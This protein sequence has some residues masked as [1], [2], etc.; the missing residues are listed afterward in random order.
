MKPENGPTDNIYSEEITLNPSPEYMDYVLLNLR[1]I[2]EK[3]RA[4]RIPV[5][6][7]AGSEG[8]TTTKRMITTILSEKGKI[9]ETPLDCHS[10]S[11]VSSTILK[12]NDSYQFAVL[13][14]GII[15]P[16]QFKLA[17]EVAQPNIG[18][19]TNIGE[20][21]LSNLGDKYLLADAKVELIRSLPEDGFAILNVDDDLVSGME[22]FSP[23]SR[24]VK[25]GLNRNAHFSASQI[26]F[27]GPEGI[28]FVVNDYYSFKLPV[29][30]ITSVLN[31][32][33]A[34]AVAR[35]LGI[36]FEEIRDALETR[37]QLLPGRGGLIHLKD[38]Y[39][40]DYSYTATVNSVGKAIESLVQFK[41]YSRKVVL[42]LGD[43]EDPGAKTEVVHRNLGYFVSALPIDVIITV[44][45]SA[46]LVGEG[47]KKMNHHPK[48][49]QHCKNLA[50]L[51]DLMMHFLEPHTSLL[52]TG[53]KSLQ[54]GKVVKK[55]VEKLQ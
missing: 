9:L 46:R 31:A 42:I 43:L 33:A 55:F 14:L 19:I 17:V 16:E 39:L 48:V 11:T 10:A 29:F 52:I 35:V 7:I 37:F 20:A 44:G 18:V 51:D 13:E 34:I 25:F 36:E 22:S 41:K 6:G 2:K 12:L 8:K 38:V 4:F 27:L 47:V 32:L 45:E 28:S 21:H 5:I 54:L 3:R 24:V 23:T 50:N 15:N 53:K 26:Q 30:S 40:L 49:V 1:K